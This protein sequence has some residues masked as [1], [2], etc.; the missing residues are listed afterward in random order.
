ML[1]RRSW[2]DIVLF[3]N[4][5]QKQYGAI[6]VGYCIAALILVVVTALCPCRCQ[7]VQPY[8]SSKIS[9]LV[10]FVC[11]KTSRCHACTV[12][13]ETER[14]LWKPSILFLY[15]SYVWEIP[16]HVQIHNILSV[17][18]FE[19]IICPRLNKPNPSS[20]FCHTSSNPLLLSVLHLWLG[21]GR[22]S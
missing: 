16:S 6:L 2:C 3:T 20:F 4:D 13:C 8:C 22:D 17:S 5:I 11:F 18:E 9:C 15:Q 21:P 1:L 7:I 12:K 10:V 14:V 19:L